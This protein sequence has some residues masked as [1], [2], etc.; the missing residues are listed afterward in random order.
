MMLN[1]LRYLVEV[2]RC[3]SIR[4]AADNLHVAPSAISRHIQNIELELGTDLFERSSRGVN[5]TP[6]GEIY[7]Q[8]AQSVLF[9]KDRLRFDIDE[10]KGLKRGHVRITTIDG[11][12][13]GHLSVAVSSFTK[14]YPGV[15][16][17]LT[18]TGTELVTKAVREGDADIGIAYQPTPDPEVNIVM[19]FA[20]PLFL[21]VAPGHPLA[22]RKSV[23]F[24]EALTFPYALPEATFGI[25][26]LIN[27][28][29]REERISL[30]PTL[31]TNSIE[32]LRGFARSG[33]GVSMLH[34]LSI[35]RDLASGVVAAIP[36]RNPTLQ[37]SWVEVCTRAT[38]RLPPAV[39]QFTNH[40]RAT[41]LQDLIQL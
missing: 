19:R 36:F 4:V 17:Q 3:R 6:A 20:D 12:V 1:P 29:C 25:R 31:E 9:E 27:A 14:L 21:I 26:R 34:S 40:L 37:K 16:F 22:G 24:S 41:F 10:L 35:S 23:D 15:T 33:A 28:Y 18:S 32:A 30:A 39:E 2:A 5:L 13:S 38:R 8:Y 11:V 7:I